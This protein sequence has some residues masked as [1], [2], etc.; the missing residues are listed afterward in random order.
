MS[1]AIA[2]RVLRMLSQVARPTADH[3]LTARERELLQLLVAEQTQKE[4]ARTLNLSPHTVDTHLRNIYA[5]LHVHS[6]SG[7]VAKALQER[8]V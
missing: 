6:R 5:K 3:G 7:A 2:G 8:L 1:A 4:I